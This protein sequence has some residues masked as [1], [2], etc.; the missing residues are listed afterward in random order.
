MKSKI[1]MSIA[2][3]I[4]VGLLAGCAS[5][6]GLQAEESSTTPKAV[7]EGEPAV[8]DG[9]TEV[10]KP[11]P[12]MDSVEKL[13]DCFIAPDP[14]TNADMVEY[15]NSYDCEPGYIYFEEETFGRVVLLLDKKC[16]LCPPYDW[17]QDEAY[18]WYQN[19][20]YFWTATEDEE[21]IKVNKRTGEYE[22][23]YALEHAEDPDV[24]MRRFDYSIIPNP[25]MNA[26]RT[27]SG[28]LLYFAYT[29][30]SQHYIIILERDTDKFDILHCTDGLKYFYTAGW[31]E[32]MKAMGVDDEPYICDVCGYTG[33]YVIWE[34]M[35][36]EYFW[37]HPETGENTP[38]VL[39]KN[40]GVAAVFVLPEQRD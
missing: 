33:K 1:F 27:E 16:K 31:Q 6:G 8:S 22:V 3:L 25:K 15:Y 21:I 10:Q 9:E 5:E 14:A 23:L 18:F 13:G 32:R 2:A 39:S 26:G 17:Y 7:I 24:E 19:E 36:N 35:Y 37:Y 40:T 12:P 28:R 38:L 20:E 11:L 34:N 29:D 30:G 4:C